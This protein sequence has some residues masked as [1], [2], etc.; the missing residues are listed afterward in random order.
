MMIVLA[1]VLIMALVLIWLSNRKSAVLLVHSS[2]ET[3]I[4]NEAQGDASMWL[5]GVGMLLLFVFA[6]LT[7]IT[8]F[9]WALPY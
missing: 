4:I 6:P 8:L 9:L 1:A 7:L 2:T 5:F 3:Q